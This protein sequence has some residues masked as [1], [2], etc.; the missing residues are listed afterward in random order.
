LTGGFVNLQRRGGL[1]GIGFGGG[2]VKSDGSFSIPNVAPGEYV[3]RANVPRPPPVQAPPATP[4]GLPTLT[5]P[6]FSVATVTVN[7]ADVT[8]VLLAP[9]PA[10][11]VKGRVVFD[12]PAAAQSMKASAIRVTAQSLSQDNLSPTGPPPALADDFT[13]ELKVAPG[14]TALRANVTGQPPAAATGPAPTGT[15]RPVWLVK[16]IRANGTDITDNGVE[17]GAQGLTGVEIELT[18]RLSEISGA[19]ADG[20]GNVV[21]DYAV[22]VFAQDRARWTAAVNR[23]SSL[24]R[25]GDDGGFKISTLPPGQYYAIALDRVDPIGW[26]DPDFLEGLSRQASAFSLTQGEMRTLDLRLFTVQ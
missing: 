18:N 14:P 6:E 12:D 4:G 23:Y 19:V 26:Q 24:A 16:S 2:Q 21:K 5:L 20:R 22:V 15:S 25:P 9:I 17:V 11:S 10:V 8:G 13:F 3:A 7:G 1:A